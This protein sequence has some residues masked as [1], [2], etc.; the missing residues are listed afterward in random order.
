MREKHHL[1][2]I[3]CYLFS[4]KREKPFISGWVFYKG[5]LFLIETSKS[6]F[7][8][9]FLFDHGFLLYQYNKV[10]GWNRLLA[11]RPIMV[12]ITSLAWCMT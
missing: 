10:Y 11:Y 8:T 5:N 7:L 1:T 12:S 6:L 2:L 4:K 9:S 3:L